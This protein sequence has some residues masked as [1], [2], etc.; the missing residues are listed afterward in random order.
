M[1]MDGRMDGYADR[2]APRDTDATTSGA[3]RRGA[4][5]TALAGVW[6]GVRF[7]GAMWRSLARWL[8]RRPDVPAG[9]T[10]FAYRSP[11]MA[12]LIVFINVSVL[13]VIAFHLLIPWE[14]PR[15]VLLVLGIWGVIWMFGMLAA[16]TVRPHVVGPD[17]L[18]V[19]NSLSVDILVPR[20]AVAGVRQVRER[21]E[22]RSVQ[23]DEN[24]LYVLVMNESTV[25]V[26]LNRPVS[27][28]LSET[29]RPEVTAVRFHADDAGGLVAALRADLASGVSH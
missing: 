4:V 5:G 9:S 20:D 15:I 2:H 16:V 24:T 12:V 29:R 21:R 19:R 3:G 11:M 23:V 14:V 25:E 7:E 1:T 22:G 17:A 10:P 27:V 8:A 26:T 18:L 28:R 6:Y 13:E